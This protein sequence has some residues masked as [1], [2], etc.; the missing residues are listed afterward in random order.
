MIYNINA[1]LARNTDTLQYSVK[2]YDLIT[3]LLLLQH[4]ASWTIF[5]SFCITS[6]KSL[7]RSLK[8]FS[9]KYNRYTTHCDYI[10]LLIKYLHTYYISVYANT[11]N[12]LDK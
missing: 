10:V 9:R 11:R 1:I 7:C 3:V 2:Y 4:F 5:Y 8:S 6:N 12:V